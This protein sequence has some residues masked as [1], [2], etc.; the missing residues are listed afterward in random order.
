MNWMEF[1]VQVSW[2]L[3]VIAIALII[4]VGRPKADAAQDAIDSWNY[5]YDRCSATLRDLAANCPVEGC[6]VC[7]YLITDEGEDHARAN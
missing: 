1:L 6:H 7:D 4:K 2:P 5:G 3:C